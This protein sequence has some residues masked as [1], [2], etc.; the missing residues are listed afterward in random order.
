MQLIVRKYLKEQGQAYNFEH[1]H[2]PSRMFFLLTKV[3]FLL[4]S[5]QRDSESEAG[6]FFSFRE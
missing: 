3:I 1:G 2:L 4:F 6:F 5:L